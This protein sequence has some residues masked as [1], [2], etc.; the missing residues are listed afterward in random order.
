MIPVWILVIWVGAN[1]FCGGRH[2][3]EKF[4]FE[5]QEQCIEA[6][7]IYQPNRACDK[8]ECIKG[9]APLTTVK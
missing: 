6:S 1:F 7:K 8:I 9:L 3:V 5:T 2:Y 4:Y